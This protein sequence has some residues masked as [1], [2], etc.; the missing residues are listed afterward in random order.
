MNL[1]ADSFP[2]PFGFSA[3]IYSQVDMPMCHQHSEV[4]I[5]FMEEGAL[6]LY[7]GERILRVPPRRLCVLWAMVPHRSVQ[8][9]KK[10]KIRILTLPVPW[11]LSCQ[12]PDNL[13][14]SVM[15]GCPQFD[16]HPSRWKQDLRL[17][18]Q[19]HEEINSSDPELRKS[20]LLGV[21]LRLRYLGLDCQAAGASIQTEGSR[22]RS[23]ETPA[24]MSKVERMA[25]FIAAHYHENLKMADI[26]S[27]VGLHEKYAMQL[28]RR[29]C[30][31]TL[32]QYIT[33]HRV[34]HAQR[35]LASTDLKMI[36]IS[37]SAGF[38]SDN[39]FYALFKRVCGVSP[40]EYRL[41]MQ[42]RSPVQRIKV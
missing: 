10:L 18:K 9:T 29:T 11:F 34:W 36:E 20:A 30:G 6:D 4:E 23:I 15:Q 5:G 2:F 38:G 35:L 7:W 32:L 16:P 40:R 13:V 33:Q 42:S 39:M 12:L 14:T 27:E 17:F 31:M 22:P 19:W 26:A 21:E 41:S 24:D 25:G 8:T 37:R 28:F 1:L 3:N